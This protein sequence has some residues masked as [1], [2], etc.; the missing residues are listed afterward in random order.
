M[1][2]DAHGI[3]RVDMVAAVIG[4]SVMVGA[5]S[6]D[7][8]AQTSKNAPACKLFEDGVSQLMDAYQLALTEGHA[9]RTP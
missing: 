4:I 5:A 8:A 1:G 2:V 3:D 7:P 9:P 6:V